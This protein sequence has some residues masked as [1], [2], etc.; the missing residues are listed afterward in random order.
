MKP[1]S[2]D[3][4][5]ILEKRVAAVRKR[6]GMPSPEPAGFISLGLHYALRDER[7]NRDAELEALAARVAELE[8]RESLSPGGKP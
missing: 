8:G 5:A 1:I 7:I 2:L 4:D 6:R 3:R